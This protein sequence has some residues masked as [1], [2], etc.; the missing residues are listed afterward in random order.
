MTNE[1]KKHSK[2]QAQLLAQSEKSNRIK[3]IVESDC[4]KYKSM[5]RPSIYDTKVN[6]YRFENKEKLFFHLSFG[7]QE[8]RELNENELS[9]F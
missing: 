3:K 7:I 2:E 5:Y 8:L 1:E 6:R 9:A 4:K